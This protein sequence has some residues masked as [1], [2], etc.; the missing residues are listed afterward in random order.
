MVSSGMLS[1]VTLKRTDVSEELSASETSVLTRTTRPNIPEDSRQ[2]IYYRN[3]TNIF[4]SLWVMVRLLCEWSNKYITFHNV[5]YCHK[6]V[7]Y[8]PSDQYDRKHTTTA[9]NQTYDM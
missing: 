6:S 8:Q 7:E 3:H 1:R 4:L 9:N 2:L 5:L